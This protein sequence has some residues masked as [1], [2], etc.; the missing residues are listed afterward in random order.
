MGCILTV[1]AG[2]GDARVSVARQCKELA[3]G[4]WVDEV[5]KNGWIDDAELETRLGDFVGN[6]VAL[7]GSVGT[8]LDAWQ[9][10]EPLGGGEC[11]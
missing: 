4:G 3:R 5:A 1:N 7:R 11:G 10:I 9:R 8:S 6:F 2:A